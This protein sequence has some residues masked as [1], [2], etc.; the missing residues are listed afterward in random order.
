MKGLGSLEW[1]S[2]ANTIDHTMDACPVQG[3]QISHI[4]MYFNV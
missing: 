1:I 2:Y 4:A 3:H